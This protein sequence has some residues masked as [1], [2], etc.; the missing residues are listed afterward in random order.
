MSYT[1]LV[2]ADILAANL[3]NPDWRI[4]DCRFS[5]ADVTAGHKSYRQ[6]HIPGARYV[7]LNRDLSS[8][9]QSYTGRHPLPNFSLLGKKL[10]DWGVNNR[11][12]IVVYDDAGGAF[13]GRMWWL[14][15]TMGHTQVAVLDGG[16]GYWQKQGLPV[17]TT[18]P[19]ITASQFRVYLDNQQWM[20]AAQVTDSLAARKIT[21]IDARTPER[22]HGQQEPIDP[23]AGH[24]PKA[25]NRPLPTNLDKSGR[26][27][28]AELLHQQFS[29]LIAAYPAEQVVHMCGS[30]VTACHN[31]LAMEIAGLSGSKLYAGS[32]SEWIT[33]RNRPV[34]TD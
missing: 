31:L 2:S 25:L 27:L 28:T 4:F 23:V 32:W 13:A 17:T 8:P 30:G 10:G 7:D 33:N 22:F 3:N 12:Q 29:K 15:R 19:K 9:V 26:F 34:A 16:F 11:C 18:L 14:L 20:D 1:T 6:G 21:L 24:V 5:L